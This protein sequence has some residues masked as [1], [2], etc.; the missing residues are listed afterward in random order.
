[1]QV[2]H[3]NSTNIF[4]LFSA[5]DPTAYDLTTNATWPITTKGCYRGCNFHQK[6]ALWRNLAT[7]RCPK[8]QSRE[9]TSQKVLSVHFGDVHDTW[10]DL[11][12]TLPA[13][14]ESF[15]DHYEQT[16]IGTDST[17]PA[18]FTTWIKNQHDNVTTYWPAFLDLLTSL[19]DDTRLFSVS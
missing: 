18:L 12:T 2:A 17:C 15:A 14:T 3:C 7:Q 9:P 10:L 4:L 8:V 19:K 6:Q 16:W 13:E 1:M 5:C 11:N